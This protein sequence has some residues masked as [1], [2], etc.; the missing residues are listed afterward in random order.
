[1][2]YSAYKQIGFNEGCAEM[3]KF[4]KIPKTIDDF[5][6]DFIPEITKI[7]CPDFYKDYREYIELEIKSY[8][9]FLNG[10][11]DK[12]FNPVWHD[13]YYKKSDEEIIYETKGIDWNIDNYL[14]WCSETIKFLQ[15]QLLKLKP[16]NK[17]FKVKFIKF[18][19]RLISLLLIR[20]S[21]ENKKNINNNISLYFDFDGE[22]KRLFLAPSFI[23]MLKCEAG[24][25]IHKI[26][27]NGKIPLKV[28]ISKHYMIGK[29]PITIR[30][31]LEIMEDKTSGFE[32]NDNSV[33]YITLCDQYI[34]KY[35]GQNFNYI[36]NELDN[37]VTNI[38]WYDAKMFC[39]KLYNK[40][41]DCLPLGYKFDL[42]TEVQWKYACKSEATKEYFTGSGEMLEWCNDWYGDYQSQEVTD[43]TGPETGE[44]RVLRGGSWDKESKSWKTLLR[45]SASPE[46]K[47]TNIG[48]RV[49]LVP[50]K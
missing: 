40:F 31:Y 5:S 30:Q 42:P 9:E 23:E 13:K 14:V 44:K 11:F 45:D 16:T 43:P 8:N 12:V 24:N 1:M 18:Q 15:T 37:T 32:E 39:E 48:F 4:I 25:F 27:N 10:A 50:I 28:T 17:N 35:K 19:N 41:K 7:L 2:L 3:T 21:I 47:T 49:A 26:K 46:T 36:D 22:G 29:V 38:T 34:N 20:E 6:F 33:E